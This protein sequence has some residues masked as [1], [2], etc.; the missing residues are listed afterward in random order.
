MLSAYAKYN[1]L[2][3][4]NTARQ[5]VVEL[6]G[7][8]IPKFKSTVAEVFHYGGRLSCDGVKIG[9]TLKRD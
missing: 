2:A 4:N 9:S 6:G 8:I 3:N 5:A 7:I 1:V